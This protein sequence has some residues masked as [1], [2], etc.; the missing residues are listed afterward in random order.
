MGGGHQILHGSPKYHDSQ[1]ID[2]ELI[3]DLRRFIPFDE[4]FNAFTDL[5]RSHLFALSSAWA[6]SAS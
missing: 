5:E 3:G 6:H 4:A 2:A 1:Q